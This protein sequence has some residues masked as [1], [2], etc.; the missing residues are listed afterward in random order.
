[1]W[2]IVASY[3]LDNQN[4]PVAFIPTAKGGTSITEWQPNVSTST[5]Y[6][7]MARRINAVGGDIKAV[8]FFQGESDLSMASSTYITNLSNFTNEAYNQFGIKTIVG[9]IGNQN[10]TAS[11]LDKIRLAQISAWET[12]DSI[13]PGPTSID[14]NKNDEGG[15]GT[16]YSSNGD[17][18]LWAERWWA[19]IENNF[20]NGPDGRGPRF[21]VAEEN[22]GRTQV[23]IIF[24]DESLPII[25]NTG[26]TGFVVKDNGTPVAL[27]SSSVVEDNK[28]RLALANPITGIATVSFGS[29]TTV[30]GQ[31][32]PTDSSAYNLPLETFID[33]TVSTPSPAVISIT[34]QTLSAAGVK[35]I[36]TTII[37]EDNS[38]VDVDDVVV[39][40][41]STTGSFSISNINC[42]QTN[43]LRV[44]CS[45]EVDANIGT[46]DIYIQVTDIA[47]NVSDEIQT[48]YEILS[49]L[50]VIY[51]GNSNTGGLV[52]VDS[53]NPY[54]TGSN[55]TVLGNTGSLA[56][57][58]YTFIGWNTSADGTGMSYEVGDVFAISSG[59]ILYAQWEEIQTSRKTSTSVAG[60]IMNLERMGNLAEANRLRAQYNIDK[61]KTTSN[62]QSLSVSEIIN[63]LIKLN[64][65][66]GDNVI[67]A[68]QLIKTLDSNQN[69]QSNSN[70]T[71]T[72]NFNRDIYFGLEGEDVKQLQQYLIN[73]GYQ[74]P[75]G[76]TG[77]FGHETRSALKQFQIDNNIEPAIGYFGPVTREAV[78]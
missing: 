30:A 22:I 53:S 78:N 49:G 10:T 64:I 36:D 33:E 27:S 60:R 71:N 23:T 32:V 63:L 54:V 76:A 21:V 28:I 12:I 68:Q 2:P 48:G 66:K 72:Y 34:A 26:F 15:D 24:E 38:G 7:S 1:M 75:S 19:A 4:V 69:T 20:Y 74:L 29:G 5:L 57:T 77:F 25:P 58:G 40:A 14:I 43:S 45:L 17:L 73:K 44:D 65:I 39:T 55:V 51:S 47:G 59:I 50:S 31:I 46:G 62:N 56:R 35:I 42:L 6:G 18:A 9:Q 37:I 52:P 16:H 3:Y 41:T 8:L 13:L 67:K 70:Q 61:P 11:N